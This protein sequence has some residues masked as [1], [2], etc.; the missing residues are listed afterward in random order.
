MYRDRRVGLVVPAHDEERLLPPTLETVPPFVDRIYVV[1]DGSADRTAEVAAARAHL[2][3][4]IVVLRH[5]SALGPGAAVVT[6]YRRAEADGCDLVAVVGGDNQMD[7]AELP[8]FLDP[9]VEGRADYAKGNRFS[10][11][12]E[13][14]EKM[15]RLRLVANMI[16][17][18]LTKIASGY[19]KIVDVVD[20]YT[21]ITR[22]AIGCVRWEKAWPG[23][24]YPM[25]FLV[26]L[27]AAGCRVVD[28]PRRP[29]YLPGERQS[30]IKGLPYALRVTP[31]LLRDFFWR[32]FTKYVLRDFHPLV[33]FYLMGLLLL[34]AGL[35][36]GG[37][38]VWLQWIDYGVSGPKAIFCALML[39]MG[40]QSLIFG[41]LFDMQASEG[42]RSLC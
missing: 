41:M 14:F 11:P 15:P 4:R 28:V 13:V 27:N 23:Y 9:L 33:F 29:I 25:D 38:L 19:F 31:M 26:R 40:F 6:G 35:L 42:P 32:L 10:R 17:S 39:L 2:D 22:E 24:G 8:R 20:G 21:A 1:D 30:Q 5:V 18:A 34:P 3:D 37:W 7:L 36:F 16:I 12:D